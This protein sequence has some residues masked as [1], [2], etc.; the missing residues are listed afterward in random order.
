M[1]KKAKYTEYSL[2]FSIDFASAV[3]IA[4]KKPKSSSTNMKNQ[5]V[6]LIALVSVTLQPIVGPPVDQFPIIYG[7]AQSCLGQ[8]IIDGVVILNCKI[9]CFKMC[10]GFF[11]RDDRDDCVT[12]FND[13]LS[14]AAEK[15]EFKKKEASAHEGSKT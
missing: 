9:G 8:C 2:S 4:I 12:V 1:L 6:L 5:W 14:P 7:Y 3:K 10:I 11:G 13:I 15:E